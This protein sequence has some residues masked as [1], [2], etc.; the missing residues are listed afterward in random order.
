[1]RD[2]TFNVSTYRFAFVNR[3]VSSFASPRFDTVNYFGMIA[4]MNDKINL[5]RGIPIVDSYRDQYRK[6]TFIRDKRERTRSEVFISFAHARTFEIT[7]RTIVRDHRRIDEIF[8]SFY[9]DNITGEKQ[10]YPTV[11]FFLTFH[12]FFVPFRAADILY[13]IITYIPHICVYYAM[14]RHADEK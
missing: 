13:L 14:L 5:A 6:L 7:I 8:F 9:R 1:M 4:S 10:I 2:N 3:A 11:R 12:L